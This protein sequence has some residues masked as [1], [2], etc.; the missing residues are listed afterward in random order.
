MG[1]REPTFWGYLWKVQARHST[2][3]LAVEI[4][5]K[6]MDNYKGFKVLGAKIQQVACLT[7]FQES[8]CEA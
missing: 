6:C 3:N 4:K 2:Q 8:R 1:S 5:L 7:Q